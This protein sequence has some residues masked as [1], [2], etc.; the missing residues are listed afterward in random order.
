M[1]YGLHCRFRKVLLFWNE[2]TVHAVEFDLMYWDLAGGGVRMRGMD[3]ISW[4]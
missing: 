3:G 2:E 4:L 1:I